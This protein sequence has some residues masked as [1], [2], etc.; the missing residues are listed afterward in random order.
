MPDINMQVFEEV[1]RNQLVTEAD[2]QSQ[3]ALTDYQVQ[4]ANVANPTNS[5]DNVVIGNGEFLSHWNESLDFDTWVKMNITTS[6]ARM[7]L[8]HGNAGLSRV[9]DG[10]DT[11]IAWHGADTTQYIDS[12]IVTPSNII[13]ETKYKHTAATHNQLFGLSNSQTIADDGMYIQVYNVGGLRRLYV[14]NENSNGVISESPGLTIDTYYRCKITYDGTTARGYID[15]NEIASGITTNI[16]DEILGIFM[17]QAT[18]TYVQD[19]SLVRKY[20]ATEPT[21]SIG[22]APKNIATALKSLGRAG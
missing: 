3:A 11:F 7:L 16:P 2:I 15:D 17:Y 10:D 1:Q 6:G 8:L 21:Y 19:F 9:S 12:L 18:G 14:E 4:L 20:T 22:A 5:P 13:Y